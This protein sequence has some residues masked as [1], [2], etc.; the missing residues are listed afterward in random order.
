MPVNPRT[1]IGWC[2]L[3]VLLV[4][5]AW[6]TLGTSLPPA[7]FT[8]VNESEVKSLDPAIVTGS[9]ENRII[10]S[11]FEGLT[12]WHPET[13]EPI[14]GVAE[15]WDISDDQTVYTFHLRKEA[16][17]SD[18]TPVTASDIYYSLRRFL[19][20]RT[21]AEYAYQGWY[22]KNAHRYSRGGSGIEPGDLVEIE[23]NLPEDA[24]NTLRGPLV[25]GKLV[26]IKKQEGSD[27]RIFTVEIDGQ[28]QQYYPTDDAQAEEY[29][30]RADIKWCRQVLLDFRTVGVK[31][32]DPRTLRI[33]LENPTPYFLSLIGFYPL[34]PVNQ[35][36]VEKHGSP[37]WTYPENLV[38]NG[39]F[40]IEFR[41]IRDRIRLLKSKTYWNREAVR[42]NVVD[43]LSVDA[44]TTAF[45][46][47]MTGK[48]DWITEVPPPALRILRKQ[49]P[50]RDDLN[51]S[52]FLSSYFYLINTTRK[53]FDDLRVRKALSLAL[54]R[55]EIT[56]TILAAG[57]MP[58]LSLVPQGI[59]GYQPQTAASENANEARRLLA[60]AGY[61]EGRGFPRI[62][63]LYNTHEAHQS[64]AELI[65][66]Q[67]QQE[68]GIAVKTRNE[69]WASYLSSQ[70]QK[71][72]NICRRGWVGDY[73]DPNT[74][75]DM[76]VTGGEQ[77]NTGWSSP[78]YDRLIEAARS[79]RE[80]VERMQLL[81]EA[82]KI[83]MEELPILPI[84]HY[85]SK[86]MVKPYVRGFYNNVQDFHPIWAI[87]IDRES[88]QPNE[89]M[90]G[91]GQP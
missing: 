74:F 13:L 52:A 76:F 79:E 47:Y 32:V 45:N 71:Q 91:K 66:K 87:W 56:T 62:D 14:P 67:W 34:Y 75:L 48:S 7:D 59:E 27:D 3:V 90:K 31:V 29:E 6:A 88:D 8:F 43:A 1:L 23:L 37:Q 12:R 46:L 82:E 64:I 4:S 85:V 72:Y 28:E 49:D 89:F 61:P 60:E 73:A 21:A 11:L 83:L 84:Y 81:A 53:P 65:R 15:S 42:L 50:P 9:P 25:Y 63:I 39:P 78:E 36:C 5:I 2:M 68:L 58:A 33:T 20:P 17:W 77:N 51:P 22:I 70:R 41:R 19:G 26:S 24:I 69:E 54:N 16:R 35:R 18:D 38:C 30:P 40:T 55:E 10:N 80:P 86:N 44:I 57:E